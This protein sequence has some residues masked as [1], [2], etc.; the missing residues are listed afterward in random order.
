MLIKAILTTVLLGSSAVAM[1]QTYQQ[2]A[3]YQHD[4]DAYGRFEFRHGRFARR[5][6]VLAN[7]VTLMADRQSSFIRIDPRLRLSRLRLQL[8]TGRA[9]IQSVFV[10]HADGRQETVAV[11]Q[12]IS[13]RM[14]RL[15]IDL[16]DAHDITGVAIN[17]SQARSARGGGYRHMRNANVRVIGVRW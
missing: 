11:N 6:V 5:Q 4:N 3:P 17:S 9:Y 12:M 8:A 2:P 10:T 14:P 7:N 15:V 1:A 13:P 16:P